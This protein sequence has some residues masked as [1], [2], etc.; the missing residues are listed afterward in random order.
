M[1][2]LRKLLE[3]DEDF[4]ALKF[5]LAQMQVE[6]CLEDL[7]A[8]N[9]RRAVSAALGRLLDKIDPTYGRSEIDPAVR[10]ESDRLAEEAINR[11]MAESWARQHSEGKA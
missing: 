5:R 10:A 2:W 1:K 11:I 9:H 3:L 8:D 7:R 4:N 6:R